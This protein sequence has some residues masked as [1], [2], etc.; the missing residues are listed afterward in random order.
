[1]KQKRPYQHDAKEAVLNALKRGVKRCLVTMPGGCGKTFTAADIIKDMGRKCWIT[2]EE[3]LGEQSAIA[4]LT[5]MGVLDEETLNQTVNHHGGLINLLKSHPSELGDNGRIIY[6]NVGMVKADV[7][8][9]NKPLVVCS[10]QT[11]WKRLDKMPEDWFDVIVCDEGDLFGSSSFK[12][13]LDHFKPKLILAI[14]ATNFRTDGQLM[15]DIFEEHVY[16]YP[17]ERAI[18][19]KYLTELNAIQVKTNIS[20][21]DVHTM[22]GDFNQKELVQTVNTLARNNLIVNKYLEYCEGQQFICFGVDVQHVIDLYEAFTEK[23]ITC[24][25]VVSDKERMRVG[26]DRKSIVRAYKKGELLGLI[27]HNIFSA[28]FDHKDCGCVILACPTKSKRKFLQQL[29]RVTRLK[30]AKFVERFGQVGTILDI[31]DG[32][33]RHKLINTHELD[34]DKPIEDRIY[35]SKEN[36]EKLLL[37][38]LD[39]ERKFVAQNRKEDKVIELFKLP[40][41]V[42]S[43][44]YKMS[45][46]AT[47]A[48]L[49]SIAKWGYPIKDMVYTKRMI[50]EIFGQQEASPKQIAFL[51]H[52]GYDTSSFVSI[53]VANMAFKELRDKEMKE[54]IKK[55][56]QIIKTNNPFKF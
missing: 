10:A 49:H 4:I 26:V 30:T 21:D 44:S 55:K 56:N 29:Y 45:E 52:K 8:D 9:I 16:D 12:A 42:I 47:E 22:A 24:E 32:T 11:L 5:E 13:P 15:E 54:E 33:S 19:E 50:S 17:I 14:T 6:E 48:Q 51:R 20:L 23:G 34:K 7:F 35:L 2:H 53:A 1:M 38:K 41:V 39:R 31:V 28:G 27:N 37:A 40:E 25:Y 18:S 46:L 36:K 3:S 43:N